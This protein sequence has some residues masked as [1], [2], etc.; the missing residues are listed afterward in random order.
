[1]EAG[2]RA[3][4]GGGVRGGRVWGGASRGGCCGGAE[5]ETGGYAAAGKSAFCSGGTVPAHRRV[6]SERPEGAV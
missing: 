6:R 5:M 2:G 3:G 4:G 1:M